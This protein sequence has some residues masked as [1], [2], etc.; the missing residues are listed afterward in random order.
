M[1]K[2][3]DKTYQFLPP[4]GVPIP[5]AIT[6]LGSRL[7]AQIIDCLITYGVALAFSLALLWSN[8]LSEEAL[9]TFFV[10]LSFLLRVPFYILSELV[11]NGRT[12]GKKILHIRVVSTDGNRLTPH[13]I[14]AR[15][16]LRE[17]DFFTPATLLLSLGTLSWPMI[18]LTLFWAG[19]VI[20]IPNKSK[21]NQRLGDMAAGTIV[22]KEPVVRLMPDLALSVGAED[23]AVFSFA[24][25]QLEIYGRHELQTLETI[26]RRKNMTPEAMTEVEKVTRTI[27]GKIGYT[28]HVP[29]GK[30]LSF[31]R[32]FYRLQR[33]HLEK[34]R[35]YGDN[36][37]DKFHNEKTRGT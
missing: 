4:E 5:L 15:N 23:T 11:W 19:A 37:E 8:L 26:L 28:D 1:S 21:L 3:N 29:A 16:L 6:T 12:M 18:V 22:I 36:R 32:V 2:I 33:E 35:L 10:L 13:Q 9:M 14:T 30:E 20:I 17:V 25:E 31:L 24:P 7:G 34:L 27:I